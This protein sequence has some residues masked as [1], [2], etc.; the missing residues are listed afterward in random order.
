[1]VQSLKKDLDS[2]LQI[3]L[4]YLE[5]GCVSRILVV[6]KLALALSPHHLSLKNFSVMLAVV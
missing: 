4:Y 6:V 3:L 5:E 2:L 1:M